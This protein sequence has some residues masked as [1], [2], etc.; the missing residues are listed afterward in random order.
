MKPLL[1]PRNSY[2]RH[3]VSPWAFDSSE[4]RHLH[5]FKRTHAV[6]DDLCKITSHII[7]QF[8][9]KIG[10]CPF[11]VFSITRYLMIASFL[12]CLHRTPPLEISNHRW[13]EDNITSYII[14]YIHI[15]LCLDAF[16]NKLEY[17]GTLKQAKDTSHHPVRQTSAAQN[18]ISCQHLWPSLDVTKFY[19]RVKPLERKSG[20]RAWNKVT[21]QMPKRFKRYCTLHDEWYLVYIYHI[22]SYTVIFYI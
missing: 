9:W 13:I 22:H 12:F 3:V 14:I 15:S 16:L 10:F 18:R 7:S 4:V 5:W 21:K 6:Q 19:E 8:G 2:L 1:C 20:E 17:N 11:H